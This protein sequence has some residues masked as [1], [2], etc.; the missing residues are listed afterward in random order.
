MVGTLKQS[1]LQ[2]MSNSRIEACTDDDTI[3]ECLIAFVADNSVLSI[4][5]LNDDGDVA[6]WYHKV[7]PLSIL[8]SPHHQLNLAPQH[9]QI[10]VKTTHPTWDPTRTR[11]LRKKWGRLV[12]S[13]KTTLDEMLGAHMDDVRRYLLERKRDVEDDALTDDDAT[14]GPNSQQ[15]Q[16]GLRSPPLPMSDPVPQS[17]RQ[18]VSMRGGDGMRMPPVGFFS[19]PGAQSPRS[20]M[21]PLRQDFRR[22]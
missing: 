12:R 17:P 18:G 13:E 2:L 3:V 22:G 5:R 10:F 21:S 14:D 1:S 15:Q 8:K 19:V 11:K 4:K 16:Q 20:P 6:D 7:R 9:S